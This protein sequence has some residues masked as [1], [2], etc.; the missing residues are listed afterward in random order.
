[1]AMTDVKQEIFKIKGLDGRKTL[2]GSIQVGGAK[3]AALKAFASSLLFGDEIILK[4]VPNIEDVSRMVDILSSLGVRIVKKKSNS[5]VC[6]AGNF[7]EVTLENSLAKRLRASIVL[8][9]PLL[10]RKGKVS[11]PHPGGCV[12]GA[13]PIDLFLDG[14]K[15]MSARVSEKNG[16]YHIM[17]PSG[18]L[19]GAEI[20]FKNQS[21]TGTETFM[22]AA[23]LAQGKTV[24]KN[25][26]MEPEIANLAEFLNKCGANIK[27]AGTHTI[28][29]FGT[30]GK[31]LSSRGKS[32][33]TL[34]DRIEAGSFLI[35][36]ALAG[37]NITIKNCNPEH[38][39]SLIGI[40]RDNGASI[41]TEKNSIMVL[42]DSNKKLKAVDI[43][44]H[45]YP[46]FPTDLQA[47]MTVLLT[48]SDGESMVF[49]TIFE[50]RLS[51]V[52]ELARMGAQIK[53]MDPHRV[54]VHGP[55]PLKGK[56]LESPDLRAGLAFI[57]AGVV[58][59][60]QSLIHNVYNIDRGYEKVE[61]R[62]RGLGVDIERVY[63]E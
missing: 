52:E 2:K 3:N 13:R 10:A 49:E 7:K 40:L 37:K 59:K 29:I 31:L 30:N 12:I 5:F 62:L 51:Y 18:K 21:V 42:G 19:K 15:K 17:A 16:Q 33:T 54:L 48:Q 60:G 34:P 43:K 1:M 23:V 35:L 9:G 20:F 24:I 44:T 4:N 57:I 32:Y 50:G 58:A 8:T 26:A 25:A 56:D 63:C 39:E 53:M 55:T 45:E 47:P 36:A 27:G 28:E 14:F 61:E 46:G 41:K 6:S 38:M 11:F 22:M